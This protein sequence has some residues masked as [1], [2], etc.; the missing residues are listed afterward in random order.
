MHPPQ[1]YPVFYAPSPTFTPGH[2]LPQIQRM[3]PC[4]AQPIGH[5]FT[6]PYVPTPAG[7]A[8][9]VSPAVAVPEHPTEQ[10]PVR[11]PIQVE[12]PIHRWPTPEFEMPRPRTVMVR[13]CGAFFSSIS[14]NLITTITPVPGGRSS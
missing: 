9:N 12:V 6:S 5:P 4:P 13:V 1:V 2:L 3:P 11:S 10:K 14:F 7:P 8:F